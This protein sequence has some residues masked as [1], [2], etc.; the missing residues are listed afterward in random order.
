MTGDGELIIMAR[1]LL[2]T[3]RA[4]DGGDAD[5][6]AMLRDAWCEEAD[7]RAARTA[8]VNGRI[9][10]RPVYVITVLTTD[11][12]ATAVYRKIQQD[13]VF[14]AADVDRTMAW[15]NAVSITGAPA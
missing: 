7:E 14:S 11:P 3:A 12:D 6:W 4:A 15:V 8:P 10:G 9:H 2:N 13:R 1:W 5:H